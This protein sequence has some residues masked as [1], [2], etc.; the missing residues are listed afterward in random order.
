MLVHIRRRMGRSWA[1]PGKS[2]RD[3]TH[4]VSGRRCE[5]L[6]VA[7]TTAH[8][9]PGQRQNLSRPEGICPDLPRIGPFVV[10]YAP[11]CPSSS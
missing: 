2:L 11:A 9:A 4:F 8:F 7:G 3:E 6:E 10:E 5:M 1:N